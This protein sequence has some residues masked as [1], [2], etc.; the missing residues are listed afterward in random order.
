[1]SILTLS[2]KVNAMLNETGLCG[3]SEWGPI[4]Q[5]GLDFTPCAREILLNATLPLC[6]VIIFALFLVARKRP[7]NR[8]FYFPSIFDEQL[9][10][11]QG[12]LSGYI[13]IS[14]HDIVQ[15]I[16]SIIQLGFVGFL[17]GW[18]INDFVDN[19]H[20]IYW[21]IG[22][23]GQFISWN[24][25]S[26]SFKGFTRK[27]RNPRSQVKIPTKTGFRQV[28]IPIF[29]IPNSQNSDYQYPEGQD[30]D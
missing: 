21:F 27:S 6:V 16:L 10:R 24:R 23:I 7:I 2:L 4:A 20:A 30:L 15:L 22:M 17:L 8:N 28:K 25:P 1:M 14:I 12:V 3:P 9:A 29:K 26:Q 11:S 5:D 13:P 18:R 19:D